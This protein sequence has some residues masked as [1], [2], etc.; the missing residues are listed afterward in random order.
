[1]NQIAY[2]WGVP[3]PLYI[4]A[5][6]VK[7]FRSTDIGEPWLKASISILMKTNTKLTGKYSIGGPMHHPKKDA[8]R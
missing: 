1:M 5:K 6:G 4:S 3:L 8:S 2:P 7:S